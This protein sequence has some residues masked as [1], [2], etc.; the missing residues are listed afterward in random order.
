MRRSSQCFP[1]AFRHKKS[2]YPRFLTFT[3][4]TV[5]SPGS[6]VS[7]AHFLRGCSLQWKRQ[8]LVFC[9]MP[10]KQTGAPT[11]LSQ[12]KLGSCKLE[13]ERTQFGFPWSKS[14]P[15]VYLAPGMFQGVCVCVCV[16]VCAR[17]CVC[18]LH[19]VSVA[20]GRFAVWHVLCMCVCVCFFMYI[21]IYH[22]SYVWYLG[23]LWFS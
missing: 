23:P 20:L 2:R 3:F 17:V 8:T 16:C 15:M 18:V 1:P 19:V 11:I 14:A 10:T 9:R 7:I 4:D 21:C 5:V 13:S 12:E 6:L 22:A